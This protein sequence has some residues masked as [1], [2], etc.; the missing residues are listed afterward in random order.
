[1]QRLVRSQTHDVVRTSSPEQSG[2]I[3]PI[4]GKKLSVADLASRFSKQPTTTQPPVVRMSEAPRHPNLTSPPQVVSKPA[5]LPKATLLISQPTEPTKTGSQ[6]SRPAVPIVPQSD[7]SVEARR[8][9]FEQKAAQ[10]SSAQLQKS[11]SNPAVIKE[12]PFG[13]VSKPSLFGVAVQSRTAQPEIPKSG[14]AGVSL[15]DFPTKTVPVVKVPEMKPKE[16][17][18]DVDDGKPKTAAPLPNLFGLAQ[19]SSKKE[20]EMPQN[21]PTKLGVSLFETSQETK[22]PA[23]AVSEGR[24]KPSL[25]DLDESKPKT[26][27]PLTSL[28][29]LTLASSKTQPAMHQSEPKKSKV[30]L[31]DLSKEA[32]TAPVVAV[33]EAKPRKS[34]FDLD[35][36]KP[37]TAAPLPSLLRLIQPSSNKEPDMPQNKAPKP[38][39]SLSETSQETKV[40][41]VEVSEG[42][43]KPSLFD[44]AE[45]KPKTAAPLPSLL[46]LIQP[47]SKIEPT[48]EPVQPTKPRKGLFDTQAGALSHEV[49]PEIKSSKPAPLL[50][51]LSQSTAA[52]PEAG[53]AEGGDSLLDKKPPAKKD[54][55]GGQDELPK[56]RALPPLGLLGSKP[57]AEPLEETKAELAKPV[58]PTLGLL[59]LFGAKP[60]APV[61]RPEVSKTEPRKSEAAPSSGSSKDA[62]AL[63]KGI[64]ASAPKETEA[65]IALKPRK[66][67][68]SLFADNQGTQASARPKSKAPLFD[69]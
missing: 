23:V 55:L 47:S 31:F 37:N 57:K 9:L 35:D 38:G 41:A 30:S 67:K 8:K 11:T 32:K 66:Q 18:F 39:V 59:G 50:N 28:L 54:L 19:P 24:P 60:S 58:A 20:P 4:T 44:L 34:L 27:A 5:E 6:V 64:F 63:L 33:P 14:P 21:K 52:K 51:I 53:K 16:S 3:N 17:L 13:K 40:P 25:F 10:D 36:S 62:A 26:A 46:G 48:V 69:D 49:Q 12:N 68:M 42:K 15:F 56:Q 65:D 45:S 29:G 1:M 43:P 2:P 7:L 22:V 61:P